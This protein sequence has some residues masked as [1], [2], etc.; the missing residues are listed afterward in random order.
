MIF[1]SN[2]VENMFLIWIMSLIL[3]FKA[4]TY[5]FLLL[6]NRINLLLFV[7]G[8]LEIVGEFLVKHDA[9]KA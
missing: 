8:V 4:Y 6:F 5:D 9:M 2:I 7:F 3:I 1:L